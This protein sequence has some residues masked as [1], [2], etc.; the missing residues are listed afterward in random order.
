[1]L[2]RDVIRDR[3][4]YSVKAALRPRRGLVDFNSPLVADRDLR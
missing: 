4:L 2:I 3:E 1:M